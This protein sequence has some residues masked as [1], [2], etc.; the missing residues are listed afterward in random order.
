MSFL[1]F[2][3]ASLAAYTGPHSVGTVDVE[4]PTSTLPKVCAE[5]EGCVSTISFKIFYPAEKP[6]KQTRPVRW[7]PQPQATVLAAYARFLGKGQY[8][9]NLFAYELKRQSQFRHLEV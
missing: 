9:A 8:T 7:L 3:D 5:P 6:S 2:L 1:P 4:I